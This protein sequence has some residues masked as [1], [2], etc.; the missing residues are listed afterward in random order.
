[1]ATPPQR[2]PKPD[3][4][5]DAAREAILEAAVVVISRVG[6]DRLRLADVAR[7]SGMSIGALQ[8]HFG[9]RQELL[10]ETF[11]RFNDESIAAFQDTIDDA[12][13][14]RR[15]SLLLHLCVDPRD[16]WDFRRKWSVWLESWAASNRDPALRAHH[17]EIYTSWREPFR[18]A[19]DDG[20]REGLFTPVAP[21]ADIVDR[22][23]ATIDG[24]AVRSLLE[25][26]RVTPARMFELLI[27]GLERELQTSLRDT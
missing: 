22:L 18:Q 5:S 20:V 3:D 10:A 23:I 1:M 16:G 21:A 4:R 7:E 26:E 8:H 12:D 14:R 25:P 19:I 2:L 9:A 17:V 27:D 15:L 6:V 11:R 24:L 13:P